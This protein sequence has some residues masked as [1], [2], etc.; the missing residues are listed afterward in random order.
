MCSFIFCG[1]FRK[2]RGTDR[3]GA[4]GYDLFAFRSNWKVWSQF[5]KMRTILEKEKNNFQKISQQ[6]R[7]VYNVKC[8]GKAKIYHRQFTYLHF[9]GKI[10]VIDKELYTGKDG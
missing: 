7:K 2:E 3:D 8:F 10:Y 1:K 6:F 4:S 9:T 5:V